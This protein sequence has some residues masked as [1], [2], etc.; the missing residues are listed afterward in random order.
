[1]KLLVPDKTLARVGIPKTA[2]KMGNILVNG[3]KTAIISDD[4]YFAY[5]KD[6]PS[7]FYTI[8]F[9]P[10]EAIVSVSREAL[11]YRLQPA[12]EDSVTHGNWKGKYGS[13]GYILCNYDSVKGDIKKLPDYCRNRF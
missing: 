2:Y 6:L 7:G 8:N 4:Q 10:R 1:M 3:K 5:V 9:Q 11:T 12:T 13:K